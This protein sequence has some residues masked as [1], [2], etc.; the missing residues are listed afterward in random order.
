MNT[1]AREG[2]AFICVGETEM[3]SAGK[4]PVPIS[5]TGKQYGGDFFFRFGM[6]HFPWGKGGRRIYKVIKGK[7]QLQLFEDFGLQ[8]Y[9]KTIYRLIV[10]ITI[11]TWKQ[12]TL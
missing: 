2:L 10:W 9:T 7:T 8:E 12:R 11:N 4:K 5:K 6:G 3:G 1:E